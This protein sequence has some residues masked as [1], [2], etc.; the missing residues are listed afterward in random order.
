MTRIVCTSTIAA[1][2]GGV[3]SS[4]SVTSRFH[5]SGKQEREGG[6]SRRSVGKRRETVG[7]RSESPVSLFLTLCSMCKWEQDKWDGVLLEIVRI[8]WRVGVL[9]VCSYSPEEE[10]TGRNLHFRSPVRWGREAGDVRLIM[11]LGFKGL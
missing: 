4:S 7:S 5:S 2:S 1:A 8:E 11:L 9:G 3:A 10:G 6:L